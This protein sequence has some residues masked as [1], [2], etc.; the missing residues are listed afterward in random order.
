[1]HMKSSCYNKICILFFF[2]LISATGIAQTIIKDKIND[3]NGIDFPH[4]TSAYIVA[5]SKSSLAKIII[6]RLSVYISNVTHTPAIV[7]GSIE[8]IPSKNPAI[9][10]SINNPVSYQ[11]I[12][13]QISPEGYSIETKSVKGHK[14]IV[15]NGVTELGLKQGV[16]RLIIKSL[17]L[18]NSLVIPELHLSESPWIPQREWTLCPWAP[19]LVRGVFSNPNAD[20]RINV[21]LYSD[22]QIKN[23]V[24]MFDAFGFNGSELLETAANYSILGSPEAFRGRLKTFAKFIRQNHQNVTLWVW[25]AQFNGY[26]WTDNSII[27]TPQKGLTAFNDPQVRAGF[28]KYYK[29]YTEMAPYTDMLITHFY[30]PGSLK[31]RADVFSYMRLLQDK[32]KAVN[33]KVKFG[34][35]FWASDSDSAYMK[36]LI[37][38][39]FGSA[40]LL[41]SGMPHLY[42]PGKREALHKEAK[43]QG[44]TMGIWGWHTVERESDQYPKMH[45]NAQVLSNFYKQIHDGVNK[46][47]P[48]QYWSEMDAYHLSNI[49]SMYAS[50][51]LL[52]NP[53]RNPDEILNEIAEGIW[54]SVN[55]TKVLNALKVI[56]DV[57]SGPTWNTYWSYKD[58]LPY[59]FGTED[60]E[61]DRKRAEAVVK[62]LTVM[63]TDTIFVP[64][65]PLPF[66]PSVFI[67]IMVP[68]LRQI[69]AFAE[70][71]LK[72]KAIRESAKKGISKEE[73]ISL[74]NEA[75]KPIPE[76]NTWIGTFGQAEARV[77]EAM[78][79]QLAKD[80]DIKI[81]PPAWMVHRDADR[82][83][84]RIQTLQRRSA[85]SIK[86]KADDN[87][88]KGEFYWP[89]EKI[90]ECI[91]VLVETGSLKRFEDKTYEL[92]NWEEYRAMIQ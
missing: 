46:I 22:Q 86:F 20:K 92:T 15:V 59:L 29:G 11:R 9:I 72:E 80:I 35:D 77:Q 45:V 7:V 8:K 25:A 70:F 14:V 10:L 27:Y 33:P 90:Q 81:T 53:Y 40:L 26:G 41:E 51:Q 63:K 5:F 24:D 31:N 83:L 3:Q 74:A 68:N 58:R 82:Y 91:D 18:S 60:P 39:G 85:K 2:I 84:Q 78:M 79:R 50:A 62:D 52:W 65:F 34:V 37:D 17:Q 38:N 13:S 57:R 43:R 49:F 71:R 55:G 89:V 64:K 19:D 12:T 4:G 76:Y 21:W 30:D 47:Q 36:Q 56:Q 16:N 61:Q 75:W 23:Y 88:G 69:Q 1:M 66:E 73:L 32:F 6:D 42:P 67:E 87:V 54:G 48:I 44:V 28:E